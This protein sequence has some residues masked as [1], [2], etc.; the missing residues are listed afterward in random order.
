MA[1]E[2]QR[3]DLDQPGATPQVKALPE[4]RALKVQT[5]AAPEA[6]CSSAS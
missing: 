5:I 2:R 4:T 6:P 3:P 1:V